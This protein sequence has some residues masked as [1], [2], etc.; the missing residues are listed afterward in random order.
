MRRG[1]AR[2]E[3]VPSQAGIGTHPR[4][5]QSAELFNALASPVGALANCM[6]GSALRG[7]LIDDAGHTNVLGTGGVAAGSRTVAPVPV[8]QSAYVHVG[9]AQSTTESSQTRLGSWSL[10]ADA[11]RWRTKGRRWRV[12]AHGGTPKPAALKAS[13]RRISTNRKTN[14][15]S[16]GIANR[17]SSTGTML[18]QE[19]QK[20]RGQSQAM[21][22]P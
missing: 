15:E 22:E 18:R 14:R 2:I 3:R 12:G 11:M 19:V 7:S 4:N 16:M 1:D 13:R 10:T 8:A 6:L 20:E 9:A 5:G 17:A 21:V